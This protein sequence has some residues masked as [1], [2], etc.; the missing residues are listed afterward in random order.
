MPWDEIK[1]KL[2]EKKETQTDLPPFWDPEEEKKLMGKVIEKRQSNFDDNNFLYHIKNPETEEIRTTPEHAAIM[3]SM[4]QRDVGVGDY[5]LIEYQGREKAKS[6][7]RMTY[8]YE[9]GVIKK[10]EAEDMNIEES[11]A[12]ETKK[13]EKDDDYEKIEQ[14][15]EF[16]EGEVEKD[17]FLDVCKTKGI[18]DPLEKE[19]IKVTDDDLIEIE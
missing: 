12:E 5:V 9:I 3:S 1:K 6:S 10:D 16:F 17:E 7:G 4:K 11:I 19:Y 2:E 18:E 14:V 13:Q 8:T 15:I